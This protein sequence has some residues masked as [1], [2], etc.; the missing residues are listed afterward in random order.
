[1][2]NMLHCR[3]KTGGGSM[4]TYETVNGNIVRRKA[5]KIVC[6]CGKE[7]LIREDRNHSGLCRSCKMKYDKNPRY[8][9]DPHNKGDA[10]YNR[11]EYFKEFYRNKRLSNRKRAVEELGGKCLDCGI[12]NLP[13]CCWDFHHVG[14]KTKPISQLCMYRW[15]TV[16]KELEYCILLCAFCH[17]IRHS[18]DE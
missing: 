8:G 14:K 15:E 6:H 4:Y 16:K 3:P 9:K 7:W 5:K 11:R 17:R 18:K 10:T 1:M 13:L 2:F 12:E